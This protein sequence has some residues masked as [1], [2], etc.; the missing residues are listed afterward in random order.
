MEAYHRE[1][2][3]FPPVLL[4]CYILNLVIGVDVPFI[5]KAILALATPKRKPAI[6]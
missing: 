4:Y 3:A 5:T 6:Y 1:Y 2:N